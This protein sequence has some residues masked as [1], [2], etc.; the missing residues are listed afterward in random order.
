MAGVANDLLAAAEALGV[1]PEV[2]DK[3]YAQQRALGLSPDDPMGVMIVVAAQLEGVAGG[4][5]ARI[6]AAPQIMT[7]AARSAVKPVADAAVKR[8]NANLVEMQAKAANRAAKTITTAA[9]AAF[10]S[11]RTGMWT[12]V[13]AVWLATLTIVAA[14][15]LAIGAWGGGALRANADSEW[16]AF[17]LRADATEWAALIRANTDLNATLDAYCATGKNAQGIQEGRRWCAVPLWRD[18]AP[19]PGGS[20]ATATVWSVSLGW[21][22][23]WSPLT[24][25]VTGLGGGLLLRRLAKLATW[26]APIRWLLDL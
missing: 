7:D 23:R 17:A 18:A 9:D 22:D 14:A 5:L 3:A 25:L 8:A 15:A 2:R 13:G 20:A 24:L 6:D 10:G 26:P 12:T 19:S 4:L 11:L 1:S 21:L 16:A